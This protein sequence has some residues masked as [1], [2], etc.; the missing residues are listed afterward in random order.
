MN[1]SKEF[2]EIKSVF[3]GSIPLIFT[4]MAEKQILPMYWP[5]VKDA[6]ADDRGI[7]DDRVKEGLMVVLS[8]QCDN[9]YCFV[10]HSY[11]L[12]GLGFSVKDIETLVDELK[13]PTQVDENEKW[14]SVLKWSFF[15]GRPPVGPSGAVV[16][17][18][19][20]IQQLT[21][22]DEYRHLFKICSVIDM[23]N[24]FSEFFSN[25]IRFENEEIYLDSSSTLKLPIP[26]L[27]NFYKKSIQ[28]QSNAEQPV[29]TICSWCKNIRDAD[30]KWH[31]LESVLT[32]L[33][34]NSIF[35]HG[36]CPNC[37]EKIMK[38]NEL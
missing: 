7:Q 35:S 18:N 14:S 26:D 9:S 2:D 28:S 33:E 21:S 11:F 10:T 5:M 30:G 29:V 36:V 8:T 32:G 31:A 4:V 19:K 27:V 6:I 20:L 12:H 13:F 17:S 3:H 16:D 1:V 24:R 37:Y 34:R 23:L 38:E 22:N 25:K 15:F